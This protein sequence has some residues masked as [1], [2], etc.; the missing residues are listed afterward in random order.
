MLFHFRLCLLTVQYFFRLHA[1][2]SNTLLGLLLHCFP[3]AGA[4]LFEMD[5][6]ALGRTDLADLKRSLAIAQFKGHTVDSHLATANQGYD[7]A[8]THNESED[9][10]IGHV[11][12][13]GPPILSSPRVHKIHAHKPSKLR[14]HCEV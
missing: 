9:E 10:T 3:L 4:K 7:D 2:A 11:P 14:E 5:A 1:D 6:G 8:S 13:R 12:S